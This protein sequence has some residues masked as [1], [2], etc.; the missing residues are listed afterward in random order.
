MTVTCN[1]SVLSFRRR[2]RSS[3]PTRSVATQSTVYSVSHRHLRFS[4]NWIGALADPLVASKVYCVLRTG[5]VVRMSWETLSLCQ[6]A[7]LVGSGSERSRRKPLIA[8][9]VWLVLSAFDEMQSCSLWPGLTRVSG[10]S[11]RLDEQQRGLASTGAA[12]GTKTISPSQSYLRCTVASPATVCGFKQ[13]GDPACAA[14]VLLVKSWENPLG[15][16][17]PRPT[18]CCIVQPA[19]VPG[20][21]VPAGCRPGGG[22]KVVRRSIGR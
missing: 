22:F 4:P 6:V 14:F 12:V 7:Q 20:P 10:A 16:T 11:R 17:S 8:K 18:G 21:T 9:I 2:F 19:L 5:M 1:Y 3:V 15:A 13:D